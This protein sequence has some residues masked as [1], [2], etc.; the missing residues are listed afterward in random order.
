MSDG[1]QRSSDAPPSGVSRT[2]RR[3]SDTETERRMLDAALATLAEHGMSVGLDD[4][5]L[6]DVIRAAGVSRTSA[7]RRWP[8]RDA[9]VQ[10]LLVEVARRTTVLSVAAEASADVDALAGSLGDGP[11]DA[12]SAHDALVEL[13]RLAFTVDLA[14][15]SRSAQFRTYLGLQATFVGLRSEELRTRIAQVLTESEDRVAA[16]GSALVAAAAD[17]FGLRPV[18]PLAGPDGFGV[19]SRALSATTT[20]FLVAALATPALLTDTTVMAAHGS[21]RP[22]E[23][24]TP[25][26]VLTGL[27][28][29][30][31]EPDPD[32]APA[33][34]L[35]DRLRALVVAA[36]AS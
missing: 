22:A 7:Y 25:V 19:V 4:V 5:R 23:W 18:P 29:S 35:A 1:R 33:P 31:V 32:A 9:F 34:D 11:A 20:G 15:A 13:L 17:A 24:S 8:T 3:L 10:D 28:L 26:F 2:R 36:G 14:A 16:R 12:A 30:S 21:S 6:E 27:V